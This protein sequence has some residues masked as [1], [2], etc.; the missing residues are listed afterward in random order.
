VSI[1]FSSVTNKNGIIQLIERNLAFNDGDITGNSTLF[2]QFTGDVNI[3]LDRA[4]ALIIQSS[5]MWHFDDTN[6][7][8]YPFMVTNLVSGQRDYPFTVDG[9]GNLILE[10]FRVMV[11]PPSGIF[12]EIYP[13]DQATTT[14]M[15]GNVPNTDS[16]INAQNQTGTPTRY[17]KTGNSIF[18]DVIPNYSINGGLKVF[19]DR[20]MTYFQTTD[21]TK[22]A[23]FAGIFHEYLA[24]RP[25]YQYAYRRAL[26]NTKSLQAEVLEMERAMQEYYSKRSKDIRTGLSAND[27]NTH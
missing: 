25:A 8:D 22:K 20:E 1:P 24:L 27:E 12:A 9:S 13:V 19:I 16:F 17:S 15:T 5:G 2:S 21:T 6:Q 7:T 26:A 3:A 14:S 23:G 18:L 11:M 10:I 4:L